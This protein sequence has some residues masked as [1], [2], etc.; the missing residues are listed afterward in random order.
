MYMYVLSLY[1]GIFTSPISSIT[2]CF[3][4]CKSLLILLVILTLLFIMFSSSRTCPIFLKGSPIAISKV[5]AFSLGLLLGCV[6]TIKSI[7]SP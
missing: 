5:F 6:S 4:T 3:K 7:V 1:V 2:S